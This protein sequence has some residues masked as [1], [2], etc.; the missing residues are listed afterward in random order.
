MAVAGQ[1]YKLTAARA[2]LVAD[3]DGMVQEAVNRSREGGL[4]VRVWRSVT[5]EKVH[6]N[7]EPQVSYSSESV[8]GFV[9]QV[10]KSVN[11][12]AQDADV[13]FQTAAL[14]AIPSRTG[15][16]SKTSFIASMR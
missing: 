7:V 3:V 11:R 13:K 6:A 12:P 9:Q 5:A 16:R 1:H 15:L 2:H 4:P 8:R 10:R 14:P